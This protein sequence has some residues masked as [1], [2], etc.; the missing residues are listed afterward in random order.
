MFRVFRKREL[1]AIRDDGSHVRLG[2]RVAEDGILF[3]DRV[4]SEWIEYRSGEQIE[5]NGGGTVSIHV[6]QSN[7]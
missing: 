3:F 6:E 7:E 5:V 2:V 4:R 1:R